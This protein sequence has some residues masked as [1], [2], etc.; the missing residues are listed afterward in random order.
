MAV[1]NAF[2]SPIYKGPNTTLTSANFGVVV[3][4]QQNFPRNMQFATRLRF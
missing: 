3:L 2:N 1:F 4:D